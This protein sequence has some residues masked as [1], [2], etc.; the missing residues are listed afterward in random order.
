MLET[1]AGSKLKSWAEEIARNL[2]SPET[3]E[4]LAEVTS[5]LAKFWQYSWRNRLLIFW[6][7]PNATLCKGFHA[8]KAMGRYVRKGE[9]G[10]QI[11]APTMVKEKQTDANGKIV[12]VEKCVGFHDVRTFDVSQTDG[13]PL[14]EALTLEEKGGELGALMP[15][16]IA[17][18]KAKGFDY[19]AKKLGALT[20]GYTDG[21]EVVVNADKGS[22]TQFRALVHEITHATAH[23]GDNRAEITREQREVEAELAAYLVCRHFGVESII[24]VAYLAGWK[25]TAEGVMQAFDKV[26]ATAKEII[27]ALQAE[28]V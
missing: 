21:K 17:F 27:G 7:K 28:T 8:W 1:E 5:Y 24:A 16:L 12:I 11:L 6:Q 3:M 20:G 13:K 18:A 14:P 23:F 26:S 25:A 15:K 10:L 4:K 22:N 19:Q 9:H 2:T